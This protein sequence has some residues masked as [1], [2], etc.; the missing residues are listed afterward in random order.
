[1]AAKADNISHEPREKAV[2]VIARHIEDGV[3]L[4]EDFAGIHAL[5]CTSSTRP[6]AHLKSLPY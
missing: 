5:Y 4:Q 2:K 1:M 6:S 3:D